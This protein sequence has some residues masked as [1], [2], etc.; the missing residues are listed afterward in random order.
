MNCVKTLS[1]DKLKYNYWERF[2]SDTHVVV[3]LRTAMFNDTTFI[4]KITSSHA[5]K[6]K[7]MKIIYAETFG[8]LKAEIFTEITDYINYLD[9]ISINVGD[10]K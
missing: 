8:D 5:P 6:S 4:A 3:Y 9:N 2:E 7:Q 10:I 1:Y